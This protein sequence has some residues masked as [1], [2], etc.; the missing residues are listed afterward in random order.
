M[1]STGLVLDEGAGGD[2]A[3][4]VIVFFQLLRGGE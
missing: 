3:E 1:G 2:D 4:G